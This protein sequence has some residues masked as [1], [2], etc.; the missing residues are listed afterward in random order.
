MA[1]VTKQD[2][3]NAEQWA[4]AEEKAA[5]AAER[6]E[7]KARFELEYAEKRHS[8]SRQGINR[9]EYDL[10][11][12]VKKDH[13]TSLLAYNKWDCLSLQTLVNKTLNV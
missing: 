10:L 8:L 6:R 1:K 12:N 5:K 9:K 11:T 13:W 4:A 2:V 7:E 3:R